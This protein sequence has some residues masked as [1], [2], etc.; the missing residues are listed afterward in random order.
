MYA[1]NL[2][3]MSTGLLHP[4]YYYHAAASYAAERKKQAK[5]LLAV[6][7]PFIPRIVSF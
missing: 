2:A 3:L 4:G 1:P 6:C 7:H 5:R